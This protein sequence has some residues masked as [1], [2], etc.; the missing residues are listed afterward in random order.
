MEVKIRGVDPQ[1]IQEIDRKV[2]EIKRKTNRNFSRNDYFKMLIRQDSEI[3]LI[4]Y[5]KAEFDLALDKML[6]S[7]EELTASIVNL[8]EVYERLFNLLLSEGGR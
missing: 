3:D 7:N 5:K 2:K 6:V 1:Y 8:T 4:N